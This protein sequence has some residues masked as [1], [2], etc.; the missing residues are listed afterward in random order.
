MTGRNK[1]YGIFLLLI[2]CVFQNNQALSIPEDKGTSAA[3]RGGAALECN[4]PPE[5]VTEIQGYQQTVDQILDFVLRGNF[6]GQTYEKVAQLVD[7][8]GARMV[9][10]EL[11]EFG[12]LYATHFISIDEVF[13][14]LVIFR[15]FQGSFENLSIDFL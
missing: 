7:T 3:G 4:L 8:Y 15:L 1:K 10:T 14:Y 13:I 12:R 6:K 9:R 11:C 5:M 2:L